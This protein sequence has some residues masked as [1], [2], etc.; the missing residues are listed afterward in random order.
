MGTQPREVV[1]PPTVADV[2][3]ADISAAADV[4]TDVTAPANTANIT[5]VQKTLSEIVPGDIIQLNGQ[6]FIIPGDDP[7]GAANILVTMCL[8]SQ[9]SN[10]PL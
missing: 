10:P 9:Q 5:T 8:S 6:N 4:T 1:A 7:Q 2:P 3:I